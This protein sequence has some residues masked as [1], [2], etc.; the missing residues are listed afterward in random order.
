M[1][2]K[3]L[4]IFI[5]LSL[6]S[7]E[8]IQYD[9]EK[10]LVFQT[11]VLNSSGQPLP[12]SHVEITVGSAYSTG[13]I[14]IGET[15][16]NGEI[17]LVFPAPKDNLGINFRVYNDD[18]SYSEK[19]VFSILKSDFENYTFTYQNC[20]LLK[21]EETASLRLGYNQ[22]TSNTIVTKVGINGIYTMPDEFYN[23][24]PNDS[25]NYYPPF[26]ILIKKN[27]TF[28]LKYTVYNTQTRA[29]SSHIVDLTIGN[30]PVNYTI[31]Y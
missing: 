20:F 30:T 22:T 13:L 31:N 8:G 5:I 1:R 21:Q 11:V 17:T 9:G 3:I 7:C 28:Q 23:F 15:D 27:Q 26:E 2:K 14:S 18:T 10:R 25:E 29:E 19:R 6:V 4:L 24:N 16:Q 12:K